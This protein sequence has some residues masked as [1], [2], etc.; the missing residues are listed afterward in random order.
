[1]RRTLAVALLL[2]GASWGDEI[3]V[4]DGR[5]LVGRIIDTGDD[6]VEILT[7]KDGPITVRARDVRKTA[8]G[9]NLYDEYDAKTV[10]SPD[11]A[12]G[13]FELGNWCKSKGL[14]WQARVEWRKATELAADHE[15]AR[16]ALGDRKV[17]DAWVTFED[18]QKQAGL[19]FFEGKWL[20]PDAV[21]RIKRARNPAQGWVLTATYKDDADKAFLE[22]WGER[23]KEASKFMWELTEGQ[24]YVEQIT[25]TDKGGPADFTIINKDQMRIRPG[26]YAEAG[27]DTITAPGQ[28]LAYTFFHE[29][30]HFKYA[31]P[32]HCDNCRHCIMS[33]QPTANQICDDADHKA[34]PGTSCWGA[35]RKHH[36]ELALLPLTRKWKATKPPETRVIVKDR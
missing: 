27:G 2:A 5:K 22:S 14:L 13:H 25:V 35:M 10:D 17:K 18:Q 7:Y 16:K 32:D 28:I 36:K 31:R 6:E 19:E 29:L 30:I 33:S 1:V 11:T 9:A 24:M 21:A 23:A 3:Q 26:V 34:P 20:K 4:A 8:R 15:G 12:D